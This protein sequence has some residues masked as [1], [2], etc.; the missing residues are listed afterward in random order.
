MLLEDD[1]TMLALL[2]TLLELEGFNVVQWI[3]QTQENFLSY[4]LDEKPDILLMDVHLRNTNGMNVVQSIRNNHEFKD[5]RIIM[6]S[7]MDLAE[8]CLSSGANAFIMKP[9]MPDELISAI[10]KQSIN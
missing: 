9:F 10:Q 7:G 1:Q 6:T 5:L 2:K 3:D 8:K 4:L